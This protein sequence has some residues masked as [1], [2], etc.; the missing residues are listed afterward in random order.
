MVLHF[1][2]LMA[3]CFLTLFALSAGRAWPRAWLSDSLPTLG[4]AGYTTQDSL[5][6]VGQTL[7]DGLS[8]RKVPTE[9][10]SGLY[11]SS[12]FSKLCLAQTHRPTHHVPLCQRR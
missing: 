2:P 7:L 5:P 4:R 1:G 8:T 10:F 9:G 3:R 12:S 11:I 6:A